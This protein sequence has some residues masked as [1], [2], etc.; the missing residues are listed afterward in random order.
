MA[1]TLCRRGNAGRSGYSRPGHE[2]VLTCSSPTIKR[3]PRR[4]NVIALNG[5]RTHEKGLAR[6]LDQAV[7]DMTV[8]IRPNGDDKNDGSEEAP[9]KSPKR[10]IA[11]A[12]RSKDQEISVLATDLA[13]I[14]R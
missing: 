3:S 8:Y 13:R 4:G 1:D 12:T 2:V 5:S 14:N 7:A 6:L 9:V 10:A 11:I